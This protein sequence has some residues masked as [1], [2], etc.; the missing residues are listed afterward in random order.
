MEANS[1][2]AQ[3]MTIAGLNLIQQALSIYDSDLKLVVANARFREMFSIPDDLTQPGASF[4]ETIR[5]LIDHGEYGYMP[6]GE[7]DSFVQDR[8]DR[9]LAF[10]AHYFERQRADGRWISVEGAPLPDGG[11]VAVYTDITS[12]KRQEAL[13]RSRSEVLSDQL[14]QYSEELAATNRELEATVI[15]LEETKRQLIDSEARMRLTAEMMPAHIAHVGPDRHYTYSNRRLSSVMPGRPSNIVGKHI[16]DTLGEQ[17]FLAIKPHLE[18]AIGGK[19]SVL[20]FTDLASTRRIRTA[21]TPDT[22]KGAKRGAYIL[23][24]DITEE[25]QTR[26]ALQHTRRREIAAQMTSGLAHDFSN[27]LTIILGMQ[28][29][30]Q[31]MSLSSEA[32]KLV[33]AT[34]A[35]SNRG[36]TLLNRIADMTG[37]RAPEMQPTQMGPFLADLKTLATPTLTETVTL[38]IDNTIPEAPILV[39][40]GMLQDSLVNLIL[41]ARD[42]CSGKG[43]VSVE[44]RL[45]KDTWLQLRVCDTG[46]GFSDEALEHALDPF[47]TTK[48]GEGSGLGLAMVYD[49]TKLAGGEVRIENTDIGGCVTIRLPLR[50]AGLDDVP[51]LVLLVEDSP[52]LRGLIRDMLTDMGHSV[53]EAASVD[54]ARTLLSEVPDISL[55]LSDISLEGETTGVDLIRGLPSDAIPAFLMTSLP[56]THQLYI[57][58]AARAP[59]LSKPFGAEQLDA[60]LHAR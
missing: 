16:R 26:V 13:L 60:F 12:E 46:T 58:G 41:N 1:A 45:V 10:E 34:L 40:P 6:E 7:I 37:H 47:F 24:M 9:A 56:Q 15:A 8:V 35:A 21:F 39:D 23:S 57:E 53:I 14:L 48:G 25:T 32:S 31:K 11:W 3:A 27:L 59:V 2:T 42:A 38:T 5:F 18:K 54:E 30:L 44:A 22:E 17:A 52:D 28:S 50:F 19:P 51:G 29:K 20:E 36:G 49:M 43:A 55:L 4:A 33:E